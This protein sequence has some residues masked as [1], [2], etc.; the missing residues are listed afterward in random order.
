MK[1]EYH[2]STT[3]DVNEAIQHY[4]QQQPSLGRAFRTEI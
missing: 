4:S 1:V 2:P 3:L